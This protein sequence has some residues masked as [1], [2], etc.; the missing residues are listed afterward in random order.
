[1]TMTMKTVL[2]KMPWMKSVIMTAIWPPLKTK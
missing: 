1:M 2:T